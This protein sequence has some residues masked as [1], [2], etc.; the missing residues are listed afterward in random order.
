MRCRCGCSVGCTGWC[1][2]GGPRRCGA[3]IRAPAAPGTPGRPGRKSCV[4][5]TGPHRRAARGAGHPPQT[6]EVGRSAALIGGLL[7]INSRIRFP[8]K[9]FRDRIERRTE[10]AGR[11][12]PL[13]ACRRPMGA[14]RL[15][16]DHRRRVAWPVAAA[17]AVRIVERHGYDIAPIDVTGSDGEMT[18]LS[19]VWPDQGARLD[20]LRGAIAVARTR[21]GAADTAQSG[22]RRGRR[23]D[24]GRR[25]ADRAVAFD[26]LAVPVRR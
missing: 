9:A 17:G 1:S 12:L 11:P 2:T 25:R 23:H 14:H 7:R 8:D 15:A 24:P 22:C 3:G 19:Y 10:P 20:R 4:A 5:A 26:H 16:G 13:S 18:V 21:S 6:N